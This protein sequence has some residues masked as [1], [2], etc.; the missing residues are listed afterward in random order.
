MQCEYVSLLFAT[1]LIYEQCLSRPWSTDAFDGTS[2]VDRV[3]VS[4]LYYYGFQER[5]PF[6]LEGYDGATW[7]AA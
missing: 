5:G 1:S 6:M 4:E 3:P 2:G 7:R